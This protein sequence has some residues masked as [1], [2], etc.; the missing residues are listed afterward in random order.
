MP[1]AAQ[2]A[3]GT[4]ML[5]A[6][7]AFP[8]WPA[9]AR[10]PRVNARGSRP[11]PRKAAPRESSPHPAFEERSPRAG[12]GGHRP[13]QPLRRLRSGGLGA[14]PPHRPGFGEGRGG[15]GNPP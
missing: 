4:R 8:A 13:N 1:R 6:P 11:P 3:R 12:P 5:W 15:A 14:E 9:T 10:R 2:A 7:N